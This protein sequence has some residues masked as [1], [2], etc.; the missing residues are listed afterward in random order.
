MSDVSTYDLTA[1]IC[2]HGTVGGGHYTSFAR[3]EAND[4]W[5]EYDDQLVTLVSEEMVQSCEAYVLFYR[6]SNPQMAEYRA[7]AIQLLNA[8][9]EQAPPSDIRFYVSKQWFNRFNTFAEPGPIDNWALLCPHGALPPSKTVLQSQLVVPLPQPLWEFF[10]RKF[11]GGPVCNHLYEC[12]I[13]RRASEALKRRQHDELNMFQALKDETTQTL[14]ALSMTWLRQWQIFVGDGDVNDDP[15]PI[16]NLSIAG[17]QLDDC[18]S[19]IRTVRAGSDYAQINSLLWRFFHSVYGGGPTIV[20]RGNPDE[21]IESAV[22]PAHDEFEDMPPLIDSS[23][24]TTTNKPLEHRLPTEKI[25]LPSKPVKVAKNVSFEDDATTPVDNM[26]TASVVSSSVDT[27]SSNGSAHSHN[28]Q[29]I[30]QN[31]RTDNTTSALTNTR[32]TEIIGK[33]DKR[34]HRGAITTSGLFGA[35][36]MYFQCF[37]I[38]INGR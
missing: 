13:C 5:Y 27:F 14:Y 3:H 20:L 19:Y 31:S 16:S 21:P 34:Y 30:L 17:Q 25:I 26:D 28:T 6:K 38:V 1:V 35:E 23:E 29:S 11:G 4:K 36:G 22:T 10:Y 24:T 7:Q 18:D 32:I 12:D 15:G 33:K 8:Y 9:A 37:I 2:H